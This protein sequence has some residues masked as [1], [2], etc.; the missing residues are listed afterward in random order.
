MTDW[1]D[2]H[3]PLGLGVVT[4]VCKEPS[5]PIQEVI[6]DIRLLIELVDLT[7]TPLQH[8]LLLALV[9]DHRDHHLGNPKEVLRGQSIIPSA[10]QKNSHFSLV[11]IIAIRKNAFKVLGIRQPGTEDSRY[12]GVELIVKKSGGIH[13]KELNEMAKKIGPNRS[14]LNHIHL[15]TDMQGN[16]TGWCQ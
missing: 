13:K 7:E 11:L 8:R 4:L 10:F 5:R 14:R 6:R 3:Q 2:Q 1:A 12:L 15:L 9:E 16:L